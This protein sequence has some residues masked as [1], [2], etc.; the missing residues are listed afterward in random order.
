MTHNTREI[1]EIAKCIG[2]AV[3]PY[4]FKTKHFYHNDEKYADNVPFTSIETEAKGIYKKHHQELQK[5]RESE[6]GRLY[7]I[8]YELR[9]EEERVQEWISKGGVDYIDNKAR[10]HIIEEILKKLNQSELDQPI[11]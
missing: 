8:L 5:A 3:A 9:A 10:L 11:S 2:R 1:E 6:T 7:K 4:V